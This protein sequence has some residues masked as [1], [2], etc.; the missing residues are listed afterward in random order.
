M[1]IN[2]IVNFITDIIFGGTFIIIPLL[3]VI[4]VFKIPLYRIDKQLL[5]QAVNTCW[6]LGAI[7]FLVSLLAEAFI[8]FYS[9]ADYVQYVIVNVYTGIVGKLLLPQLFWIKK[10]RRSMTATIVVFTLWAI[11]FI[12]HIVVMLF[13]PVSKP[14]SITAGAWVNYSIN[15]PW[16]NILIYMGILTLVYLILSRKAA[17]Q[18]RRTI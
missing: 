10:F 16:Q 1:E 9:Q 13:T 4:Y 8:A 18:V 3:I 7:I 15:S 6:L 2:N 17:P 14:S 5:I 11:L 12:A